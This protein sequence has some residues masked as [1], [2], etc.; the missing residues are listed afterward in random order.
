MAKYEIKNGVGIIP[1]GT[2]CIQDY[3][4]QG[5]KELKSVVIPKSVKTI[6]FRAFE[7]CTGL[8]GELVIPD[9]VVNIYSEAF[10]GCTGLTSLSIGRG[11][12][13]NWH[14]N[15]NISRDLFKDCTS[16]RKIDINCYWVDGD[17]GF[18]NNSSIEEI[19]IGDH[20][21][22]IGYY[23]FKGCTGLKGTLVIPD[24]VVNI[25]HEAFAGC[26]GLTSLSIG[27]G[28][29]PDWYNSRDLFKGCT[30]LRK[31]D[32]NCY[33]VGGDWGFRNNSSIE[34]I[35]IGD[36]VRGI[37]YYAF[38][39]CTG[40]KGT[41]VIPDN[42]VNIRHE[43]FAGCTG[44]TS[45]LIGKGLQPDW[46][47]NRDL[48][49]GCTSLKS[50]EFN[51]G[52]IC[53]CWG[54][55]D[56]SSVEELVLGEK[57]TGVSSNTFKGFANLKNVVINCRF[58]G[59]DW[60]FSSIPS[61]EKIVLGGNVESIA[62]SAFSGTAWY[63]NQPDGVVYAGKFVYKYK[64]KMPEN[65]S[66][67][68]EE[69][70]LGIAGYAFKDC[71]GL[72]N[73]KLPESMARIGRSAFSN[74]ACL[75]AV[76]IN[77][78]ANWCNID[79]FDA[80]SNPLCSGNNLYLNGELVTKLVIPDSVTT[81]KSYAFKNCTSLTSVVIPNGVKSIG[82]FVFSGC[83]GL[84]NLRI[85][86]GVATLGSFA[87]KDCR[88]LN[89]IKIPDSVTSIGEGAFDNTAWYTDW[90][91]KQPDGLV[92]V[93]KVL[94]KYKGVMPKNENVV[95]K[96][97]TLGIAFEAFNGCKG[98]KG[99]TLPSTVKVIARGAFRNCSG[100]ESIKLGKNITSVGAEAFFGCTGLTKL[101]LDCDTINNWGFQRKSVNEI[102]LGDNVKT[103]GKEAFKDCSGI[104]SIIIPDSVTTIEA[105]AFWGCI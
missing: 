47:N 68:I 48:F 8:N 59:E 22:G 27:K 55:S 14:N 79:F 13:L 42:V 64:G 52:H 7:G 70:T 54:F 71:L 49:K 93:G 89:D 88:R 94:Y 65:T 3:A 81:I 44:L 96:D 74:C 63:K 5:C 80:S 12:R 98:M 92:Y 30:N 16:L 41:L 4:F 62:H 103:L 29:Q 86:I 60:G 26:T 95:L 67:V 31:I 17:W 45:L 75:A 69:G 104:T 15:R 6:G 25:R 1:E 102:I 2:T 21:R 66:I 19:L 99:I 78:V 39:G 97:G 34:E 37:G 50:V 38:K 35:L 84:T 87:F 53:D 105:D 9:N 40:L 32:I 61:I 18:R 10:S 77:N 46:Y 11:L 91:N 72:I 73:I 82:R 24:N 90:Y 83:S 100:L 85:P 43:A 51:C 33:W 23:A 36:H 101:E 76:H 57:V 58:V 56:I 28:L 20:V